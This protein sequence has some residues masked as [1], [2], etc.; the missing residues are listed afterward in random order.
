M[1]CLSLLPPEPFELFS[2]RTKIYNVN[3]GIKLIN[4]YNGVKR[5]FYSLYSLDENFSHKNPVIDK[6]FFDFDSDKGHENVIKLHD[7]CNS[8]NLKHTCIF[9]GGGFHFYIFTN[10]LRL[11]H[12][13][14][15][16]L[17]IHKDIMK[18]LNFTY[19]ESKTCDVDSHIVGDVARIATLPG[20]FNVKRG[21]YAI[22]LTEDEIYLSTDEIR[23]LALSQRS[24]IS[25]IGKELFDLTPFIDVKQQQNDIEMMDCSNNITFNTE[26]DIKKFPPCVQKILLNIDESGDWKARWI[27][28]A[29]MHEYGLNDEQI[30]EMA[31]KYFG[32]AKRTD[33]YKNNYNHW[34]AVKVLHYAKTNIF[35]KCE[36]MH[37]EGR[38]TGKCKW[39]R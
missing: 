24:H 10:K 1:N 18:E 5:V 22:G 7:W 35:P 6:I 11:Q 27:A 26:E 38:C 3:E 13:K 15:A 9:S 36:N 12:S 29:F 33:K 31:K 37:A 17:Q 25:I 23:Q 30:E 8:K 20:T 16:L 19:G 21:R 28:T 39:Y 2:Y 14:E 4:Q 32:A 34:K